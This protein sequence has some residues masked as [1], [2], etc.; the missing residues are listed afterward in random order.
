MHKN[1]SKHAHINQQERW[2]LLS[3][4]H[5]LT[6]PIMIA[7]SFLWLGLLILDLV[8]GLNRPLEWLGYGIWVIFILDFLVELLIA[9]KRIDYVRHHWLTALSILLPAFRIVRVVPALKVINIARFSRSLNL[10]RWLTS[11][12]RS[13]QALHRTWKR[14]G[15]MYVLVLTLAITLSGAAG[16]VHFENLEAV[17]KA[18]YPLGTGLKNYGDALWWT[19]MTMTTMGSDYWP[20]TVE[21]RILGWLLAVYAF[22]VFG[23][24]TAAIASHFIQVDASQSK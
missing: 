10:L 2:A 18:G 15:V 21:G 6:Q 1:N 11:T 9:P 24:I 4:I 3:E 16:M 19:A 17:H 12:R 20:K 7:L 22:A 14:R 8:H 23:Y 13:I 5:K